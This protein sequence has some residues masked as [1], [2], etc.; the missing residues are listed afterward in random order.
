VYVIYG[1]VPGHGV[2]HAQASYN[3]DAKGWGM[4]ALSMD[5]APADI[6]AGI[7]RVDSEANSRQYG[8]VDLMGRAAAFTGGADAAVA[9][10]RFGTAGSFV[11]SA[12]GNTLT[13]RAVVDNASQAFE[14]QG[15]DLADRLINA[16]EAGAAGGQGDSRCTGGR[17][18]GNSA[19]LQV[20]REGEDPGSYLKIRVENRTAAPGPLPVLRAR[21][22]EWRQTHPCP[23]SVDAGVDG[24]GAV[25]DGGERDA[26]AADAVGTDASA[27]NTAGE[28]GSGGCAI[29]GNPGGVSLL[30]LLALLAL[31][32]RARR[33]ARP[34]GPARQG[35][36][37]RAA[38]PA[39]NPG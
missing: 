19:F 18:P 25:A 6:I 32:N 2:I 38:S 36:E 16:L 20:D 35:L 23:S 14:A 21:F 24:A 39:A 22:D 1:G 7:T 17:I 15:C 30:A 11:Y 3:P 5:R 26:G 8:V 29:G 9:L 37:R 12:Q 31:G 10:H 27:G 33:A 28:A 4:R 34:G 13:G